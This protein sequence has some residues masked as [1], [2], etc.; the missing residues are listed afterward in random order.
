MNEV[1]VI[2]QLQK[3]LHFIPS[4]KHKFADP[5]LKTTTT[6]YGSM[7]MESRERRLVGGMYL[8]NMSM[9]SPSYPEKKT[10]TIVPRLGLQQ[11]A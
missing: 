9:G 4:F 7:M 11:I 5:F 3:L 8:P 6:Y 10:S 1:Q 2:K